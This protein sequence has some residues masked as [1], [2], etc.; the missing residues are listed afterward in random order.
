MYLLETNGDEHLLTLFGRTDSRQFSCSLRQNVKFGQNFKR[1]AACSFLSAC[2]F[3]V[4]LSGPSLLTRMSHSNASPASSLLTAAAETIAYRCCW[5][6]CWLLLKQLQ[7]ADYRGLIMNRLAF[8]SRYIAMQ[9][10]RRTISYSRHGLPT[11]EAA[12]RQDV[13]MY[14]VQ[15]YGLYWSVVIHCCLSN[16]LSPDRPTLRIL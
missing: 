13:Y 10:L 11:T 16:P 9:I 7:A 5:N 4:L 14:T 12:V 6:S 15:V 2:F 1:N 8:A 3:V